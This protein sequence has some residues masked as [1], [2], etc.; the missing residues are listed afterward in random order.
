MDRFGS[1][2]YNYER[3]NHYHADRRTG[4]FDNSNRRFHDCTTQR[5]LV[6]S[7][8]HTRKRMLTIH[9]WRNQLLGPPVTPPGNQP[10]GAPPTNPGQ[11]N[12]ASTA[13]GP[14]PSSTLSPDAPPSR[15][16]DPNTP[17]ITPVISTSSS[18]DAGGVVIP[19][20]I[21]LLPPQPDPNTP[22]IPPGISTSSS[23]DAGGVVI[24]VPVTPLPPQPS[25]QP[26]GGGGG[27]GGGSNPPQPSNQPGGGGGG[28]GGGSN[29]PQPSNQPGGGGGGGGGG[30]NPP[31]PSN[32]PGGGGGGGGGGGSN[33]PQ[34]SNQPGGGGGGGGGSNRPN[35]PNA[36]EKPE[37]ADS[38]IVSCLAKTDKP[39]TTLTT[40][41]F[42]PECR[43]YL[44]C[45]ATPTTTTT[46]RTK[47]AD[48]ACI[49]DPTVVGDPQRPAE[50]AQ[51]LLAAADALDELLSKYDP[52]GLETITS[53]DPATATFT[54]ST[55]MTSVIP[56]PSSGDQPPAPTPTATSEPPPPP[57]PTPE[58]PPP[59]TD[60]WTIRL[61]QQVPLLYR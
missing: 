60:Q 1:A 35:D 33:P 9:R 14:Q 6:S 4:K 19:V 16:P 56:P 20:P 3:E 39:Q 23:T 32:Q 58:P 44:A 18:T 30:S 5:L 40:S 37:T 57:D 52:E 54:P 53:S 25:N 48:D 45:T 42:T 22:V 59:I 12:D 51:K 29:P 7:L 24:P 47:T 55:L 10:S 38:C 43:K 34:P 46:V 21:T 50:D 15:T 13:N 41:C 36:C 61:H 26:G 8:I 27:G 11:S 17:A 2:H 31:Q 28:G 49:L